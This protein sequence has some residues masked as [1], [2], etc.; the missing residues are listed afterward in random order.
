MV[1]L[2]TGVAAA[3]AISLGVL[4]WL[5]WARSTGKVLDSDT[6]HAAITERTSRELRELRASIME[7][8]DAISSRLN[9]LEAR[10]PVLVA[11]VDAVLAQAETRFKTARAAEE[12]A[13]RM[14]QDDDGE[15]EEGFDPTQLDF[16]RLMQAQAAETGE[17]RPTTMKDLERLAFERRHGNRGR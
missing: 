7:S 2:V 13:R 11:E 6:A 8:V 16:A 5:L 17:V 4:Y 1:P 9:D 15:E 14:A 12:R 3:A 10:F